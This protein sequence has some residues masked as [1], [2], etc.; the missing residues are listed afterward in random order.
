MY[1]VL[2]FLLY[3]S[4]LILYQVFDPHLGLFLGISV[5]DFFFLKR[6]KGRKFLYPFKLQMFT[7]YKLISE[8]V[9][10]KKSIV[11]P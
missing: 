8:N 2:L 7:G 10:K 9:S 1:V 11:G 5:Y 4:Y 3:G 6:L